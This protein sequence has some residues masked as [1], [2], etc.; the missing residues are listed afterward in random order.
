MRSQLGCLLILSLVGCESD[1]P[2][3]T[4]VAEWELIFALDAE[5]T[6]AGESVGVTVRYV[7]EL[8]G[9]V[10]VDSWEITS[11][12]ENNLRRA[13][14]S[15]TP[16]IAGSHQLSWTASVDEKSFDGTLSLEVTAAG[17]Y[18]LNLDLDDYQVPAGDTIQYE[19]I[20]F[21]PWGN[22]VD[23]S[24]VTVET[25]STAVIVGSET[26]T[27][28]TPGIY[29]A[30]V[31]LDDATDLETFVVTAGEP[32]TIDLRLSTT[33]LE[34]SETSAATVTIADAWGNPLDVPWTLSVDGPG[35]VD[36]SYTNLTFRD[37]GWY[38]VTATID[39]TSLSDSIGPFLIDSTGPVI[40]L[41]NPHGDWIEG[42]SSTITGNITDTWSDIDTASVNGKA[43]TLDSS[44]NF[45]MSVDWD[46]GLNVLEVSATDTDGNTSNDTRALLAG[47][48]S[49]YGAYEDD[50][51]LARLHQGSGGLGTLEVMGEGLVSATDID[52]LIPSP[53]YSAKDETSTWLGTFTWYSV[54]LY[55][56][57]PS[58]GDVD[59]TLDPRSTGYLRAS[60]KVEDISMDWS[61][62]GELL[63][64][65]YS[66]TGDITSDDITVTMDLY[67]YVY[68][69]QIYAYIVSTNVST[70]NFD[71]DLAGA[72]SLEEVLDFFGIDVDG[73]I[74]DYVEDALEDV[75]ADE[76][77]DLIEDLLQDLEL[78]TDLDIEDRT[79]AFDATPAS[80]DVDS[81]GL[82]L[83][84]DTAFT[85]DSWKSTHYAGYG[86]LNAD[87]SSPSWTGNPGMILALD[88][89]FLNQ[90]LF[91]MWGGGLVD[92]SLSSSELGFDT[93]SLEALFPTLTDLTVTTEAM[94]PPVIVPS[95]G[96]LQLQL[97]D[98]RI[99][100][101]NGSSSTG[102]LLVD[103]YVSTFVDLTLDATSSG[104][105][106]L[107]L[108]TPEVYF[109]VVYPDAN[110][111]GALATEELLAELIP[112]L[113]PV[114]TDALGEIPIPEIS[115]FTL[116]NIGVDLGGSGNGYVEV[117]GDL[118][119]D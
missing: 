106:A 44:G 21:D 112:L 15:L 111:A 31:A 10:P 13:E 65:D 28:T 99:R 70:N 97:G 78:S 57:N 49:T 83:A 86:P 77:P 60:F 30:S 103:V 27:S 93:T 20:G 91:S 22:P 7:S 96:D 6:T 53:A 12:L 75:I 115:G 23:T 46:F 33:Q 1:D 19:V 41:D 88:L 5:T 102:D 2:I 69:G 52:D 87:Y 109:D 9:E 66:Y 114:V 72:D 80:I 51:I 95:G 63:E 107:E 3:L 85:V 42:D 73:L 59:L 82:T 94:L 14:A 113:L 4:S 116:D 40:T 36:I 71:F 90:A 84:L 58:I 48:F 92:L 108:G 26:L 110:T 50:G 11:D 56:R 37:E 119:A 81:T 79:Y 45:S 54:Y 17:I 47:E 35:T 117:G 25:D 38:T 105:L 16:T 104:T 32:A 8:G 62:S 24:G 61:A 55:V 34:V 29:S 118:E 43:V 74:A 100:M 39:G 68:G 98:M 18:T 64:V 76:V 101:Y 67:P 89:D